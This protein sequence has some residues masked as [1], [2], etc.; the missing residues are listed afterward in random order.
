[1]PAAD[2]RVKILLDIVVKNQQELEKVKA[3]FT[4]LKNTVS[5]LTSA[6]DQTAK[7]LRS[8]SRNLTV[9]RRHTSA[10]HSAFR[11]LVW[12]IVRAEIVIRG[13][14]RIVQGLIA[15]FRGTIE[16]VEEF[17]QAIIGLAAV[18]TTLASAIIPKEDIGKYYQYAK[19]QAGEFYKQLLAISAQTPVTTQQL[20]RLVT[21]L[22]AF[23]QEVNL[24]NQQAREGLLALAN[25]IFV[26]TQGQRIEV[27]LLQETRALLGQSNEQHAVLLQLLKAINPKIEEQLKLWRE[28]GQLLPHLAELLYPFTFAAS[29]LRKTWTGVTQALKSA[30]EI[31]K[32]EAFEDWFNKVTDA[33]VRFQ[34]AIYDISTGQ[35]GP[36][37]E[38]IKNL[39]TSFTHGLEII[40]AALPEIIKKAE[41]WKKLLTLIVKVWEVIAKTIAYTTGLIK[42]LV[43][44]AQ[45]AIDSLKTVVD[46][47]MNWYEGGFKGLKQQ[48]DQVKE[49][50]I[51]DVDKI[52][53]PIYNKMDEVTKKNEK[54]TGKFIDTKTFV[55]A[56]RATL[57][58]LSNVKKIRSYTL[59]S[60]N[61]ELVASKE[62]IRQLEQIQKKIIEGASRLGTTYD[63][64]KALGSNWLEKFDPTNPKTWEAIFGFYAKQGDKLAQNILTQFKRTEAYIKKE[65]EHYQELLQ[66]KELI[67]NKE[68]INNRLIIERDKYEREKLTIQKQILDTRIRL[69]TVEDEATKK[70]LQERLK[71]LRQELNLVDEVKKKEEENAEIQKRLRQDEIF[72]RLEKLRKQ[73]VSP[74]RKS[75]LEAWLFPE[76]EKINQYRAQLAQLQ[77]Q[78]LK[79]GL[80]VSEQVAEIESVLKQMETPWFQFSQNISNIMENTF[81]RME[82]LVTNWIADLSFD[83]D[84]LVKIFRRAAAEIVVEWLK[85]LI[86]MRVQSSG[87]SALG[88]LL[89][90]IPFIGKFF[91]SGSAA[92]SGPVELLSVSDLALVPPYHKG[93]VVGTIPDT[94]RVVPATLFEKAPRLHSGLL[95]NEFPAILERGEVVLPKNTPVGWQQNIFVIYAIDSQSFEDAVRRNPGAIVNVVMDNI[96]NNNELAY[97]IRGVL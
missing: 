81:Q 25:A 23:G 68:R 56:E 70:I 79:E 61:A 91:A 67:L 96:K 26:A 17:K 54:E 88:G 40:G 30:F 14:Q 52:W 86:K 92:A 57:N 32:K 37:G 35:L 63:P 76:N 83:L 6:S 43:R 16:S 80:D 71:Y 22:E 64:R 45:F 87:T 15:I 82:D 53:E 73:I 77:R 1:M 47:F 34:Q 42:T 74:T 72:N 11:G 27:Q 46:W 75:P 55:Q 78:A 8:I 84:G 12:N 18:Q 28:Q 24:S 36:L 48:L 20:F 33:A 94:F 38:G 29:D 2:E 95:P 60:I 49:G 13:F 9:V 41:T 85:M 39:F 5:K 59:E 62:R 50:Y 66:I 21:I 65:K 89:G 90:A 51:S 44:A 7:A 69:A 97:E 4:A 3:E 58:I 19:E 93:G 31:L 10:V